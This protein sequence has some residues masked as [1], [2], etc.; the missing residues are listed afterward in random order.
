MSEARRSRRRTAVPTTEQRPL[1]A[2]ARPNAQLQRRGVERVNAI[3]DAAEQI[4]AADGYEAATL[5]AAGERAGIPVASVYHYFSDRHQVDA[6]LMRRHVEKLET[7]VSGV[8]RDDSP[9]ATLD[10]AVG[11]VV[12]L[13]LA[14]FREHPSCVE[15]WF[16]RRS[17]ALAELVRAFDEA[18]A[19]QLWHFARDRG[20]LRPDTPLL[21]MQLA[22]EAGNRLFDVAFRVAPVTG[23]DAVLAEHRR[24]LTSYLRTYAPDPSA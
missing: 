7:L 23:D 13:L 18:M 5:K 11:A 10:S 8:F 6:E 1:H 9:P 2:P 12:D 16:T 4:L 14:Y 17:D 3:L 24:L 19:E 21:V 20:L 15:L 22:F